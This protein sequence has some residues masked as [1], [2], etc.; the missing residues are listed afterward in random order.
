MRIADPDEWQKYLDHI[1]PL[2]EAGKALYDFFVGWADRAESAMLDNEEIAPAEAL[3]QAL[4]GEPLIDPNFTG[5]ALLLLG[6]HWEPFVQDRVGFYASLTPIE[7]AF[8]LKAS[9]DWLEHNSR[10]TLD[11]LSEVVVDSGQKESG[12]DVAE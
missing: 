6:S 1:E 11:K 3:R 9:C 8:Y 7:Q 5:P 10:A 12:Y 2:G 4:A